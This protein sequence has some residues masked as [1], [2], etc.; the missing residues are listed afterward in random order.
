MCMPFAVASKLTLDHPITTNARGKTENF[1][2]KLGLNINH[3]VATGIEKT[4]EQKGAFEDSS[5][6]TER[7]RERERE[8][9]NT[10]SSEEK[11]RR[12]FE[13]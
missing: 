6:K 4:W 8:S 5:Y 9:T 13:N 11:K 1:A 10:R 12:L 7:E 2:G 3:K